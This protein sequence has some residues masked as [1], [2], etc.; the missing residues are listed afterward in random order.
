MAKH[1]LFCLVFLVVC[2]VQQQKLYE[3]IALTE[4]NLL[5]C[6]ICVQIVYLLISQYEE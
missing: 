1:D 4:R 5:I 3:K 2:V 6:K